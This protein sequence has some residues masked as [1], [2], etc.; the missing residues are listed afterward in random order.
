M[1][2]LLLVEDDVSLRRVMAQ[3]LTRAGYTVSEARN[4]RVAIKVLAET[5]VDIVVTDMIMPEMD[6]VET[7]R[8]LRREYPA[9]KIVAISGGGISSAE[10]YLVIA[11]KMGVQRTLAKPFTPD[12]LMTAIREALAHQ[13]NPFSRP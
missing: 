4:G 12:E 7:I 3:I 1:S 8:F 6:G 11:Q 9:V 10:S 13:D 2:R 5:P